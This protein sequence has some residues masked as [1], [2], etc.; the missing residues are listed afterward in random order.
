MKNRLGPLLY[1]SLDKPNAVTSQPQQRR[2]ETPHTIA[3]AFGLLVSSLIFVFIVLFSFAIYRLLNDTSILATIV[4]WIIYITPVTVLIGGCYAV[5]RWLHAWS[6]NKYLLSLQ[7]GPFVHIE[8]IKTQNYDE[9]VMQLAQKMY[10]VFARQADSATYRNVQTLTLD[11]SVSGKAVAT[12]QTP[13]NST[14]LHVQ[15]PQ[16]KAK[17][18]QR[19]DLYFDIRILDRINGDD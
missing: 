13:Q 12:P 6:S 10:D 8:S 1:D 5:I 16:Q 3:I 17:V 14:P 4:L 7:N 15:N 18:P 11:Q 2:E 19:G 9:I